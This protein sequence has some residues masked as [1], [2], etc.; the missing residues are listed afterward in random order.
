MLEKKTRTA[1]QLTSK[2]L[3]RYVLS[4]PLELKCQLVDRLGDMMPR[5]CEMGSFQVGY[6]LGQP[7]KKLSTIFSD[8]LAA[9]YTVKPDGETLLW[10]DKRET[11]SLGTDGASILRK[12]STDNSDAPQSKRVNRE[13]KLEQ[14]TG[15]LKDIYVKTII[16]LN[17][18][19]GLG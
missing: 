19:C 15:E 4:T 5:A 18:K 11:V 2:G 3:P 6:S 9:M 10:C 7:Q 1:P 13:C 17:F 12:R 8:D 14:L 16:M